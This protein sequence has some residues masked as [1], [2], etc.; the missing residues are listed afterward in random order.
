[1]P[2]SR[3]HESRQLL[4]GRERDVSHPSTSALPAHWS[5]HFDGIPP[6]TFVVELVFR[7]LCLISIGS[8]DLQDLWIKI[9]AE[10]AVF[11]AYKDR[12]I[13]RVS[14]MTVAV[15]LYFSAPAPG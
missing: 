3:S 6:Y 12:L 9:N 13:S 8:L 5:C 7:G 14:V 10:E 11:V 4:T 15:G 1:M 2:M